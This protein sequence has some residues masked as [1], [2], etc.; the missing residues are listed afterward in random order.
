M[1]DSKLHWHW[2]LWEAVLGYEKPSGAPKEIAAIEFR[3]PNEDAAESFARRQ[4]YALFGG[5]AFAP[6]FA[7]T[8]IEEA[9]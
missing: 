7:I 3:A 8:R 9:A 2:P 6:H 1:N 5:G 4:A